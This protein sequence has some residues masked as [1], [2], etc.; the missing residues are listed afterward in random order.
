M[1]HTGF[2]EKSI[3]NNDLFQTVINHER[4]KLH[5]LMKSIQTTTL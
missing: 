5:L 2:R 4:Y 3:V 1:K